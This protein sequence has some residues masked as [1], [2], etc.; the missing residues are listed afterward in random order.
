MWIT[1]QLPLNSPQLLQDGGDFLQ[2]RA[3]ELPGELL[4]TPVSCLKLTDLQRNLVGGF[5]EGNFILSVDLCL[6]LLPDVGLVLEQNPERDEAGQSTL[7]PWPPADPAS[8]NTETSFLT[9]SSPPAAPC[10]PGWPGTA[11]TPGSASGCPGSP[12]RRVHTGEEGELRAASSSSLSSQHNK[13]NCSRGSQGPALWHCRPRN[14]SLPPNTAF[15][16]QYSQ[17]CNKTFRFKDAGT[18][19]GF[20][21]K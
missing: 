20:Q 12:G 1:F 9:S 13:T 19:W 15:K 2:Q 7:T 6:D 11:G 10:S 16:Y 17:S 5:Q 21:E 18:V 8:P 4:L 14:I 3:E